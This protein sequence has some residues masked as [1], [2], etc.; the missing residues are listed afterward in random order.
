MAQL[1]ATQIYPKIL[2]QQL[3]HK[4]DLHHSTGS[5]GLPRWLGGKKK[6]NPPANAGDIR[7][8][9]SIPGSGRFPW[10]RAWQPIQCS[11]LENPMD[12]RA[13]QA[14]VHRITQSWI[15]L[16]QLNTHACMGHWAGKWETKVCQSCLC[17]CFSKGWVYTAA[18]WK[19]TPSDLESLFMPARLWF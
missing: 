2:H 6:K 8:L 16:K 1:W 4:K 11:C 3:S 5:L 13:C 15:Q 12:R 14:T 9:G 17:H 18:G 19:I 10:R 7:D